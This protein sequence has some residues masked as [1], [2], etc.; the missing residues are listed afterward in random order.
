[1]SLRDI[2]RGVLPDPLQTLLSAMRARRHSHRLNREWGVSRLSE[3]LIAELGPAVQGGP[4]RGLVLPREA[5]AEH[6]GP[7]LLG[8]YEREL[9]P[10]WTSLAP[11]T[12]PLIVNVGG[13]V[14]Y[15]AAGLSR[16]LQAPGVAYD[17][18]PWAR[19]VLRQTIALNGV[20]VEVRGRCTR[21]DLDQLP[22]GT[23]VMI[24]C[25]GCEDALLRDPLPAG[26]L[27]SRLVVELHGALLDEDATADRL[28]RS[29]EVTGVPSI[30]A[31]A[32]P[33]ALDFLDESDRR[34]A[35]EEIRTPQ[36]WLLCT[37]RG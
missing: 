36:R 20:R 2:A 16:M 18:D 37:P 5:A 28:R 30:D 19:R 25:D 3:R 26:L 10:F 24:D 15:Y 4:F 34:L 9:H 6:I 8:T 22:H 14:G 33:A 29:H 27:R 13:K 35:V 1:M 21:A 17:A 23:L 11:G 12:I 7:Y 32:P 31:P